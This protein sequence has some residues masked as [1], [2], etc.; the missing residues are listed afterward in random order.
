[1]WLV[2]LALG[3]PVKLIIDTDIGGGGCNDVDDVVAVCAA[4]AM[5]N[6]GEVE[7]LA[8]VLNTAPPR[9]VGAI[10]VLNT[11]YDRKV[12]TRSK[13][14]TPCPASACAG[15]TSSQ[16]IRAL[17]RKDASKR[18]FGPCSSFPLGQGCPPRQRCPA[19]PR[20]RAQSTVH[21]ITRPSRRNP[22]LL[23]RGYLF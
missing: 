13:D 5:A 6:R 19:C 14:R 10:S 9:C 23:L 20:G 2:A 3:A 1:M 21:R 11:F 18:G 4:H 17:S 16:R 7:L 8:I 15:R 12:T 22:S